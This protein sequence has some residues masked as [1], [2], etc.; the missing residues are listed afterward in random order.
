MLLLWGIDFEIALSHDLS[1]PQ[2]GGH[3]CSTEVSERIGREEGVVAQ[4]QILGKLSPQHNRDGC[5]QG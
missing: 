4:A 3:R 5:W 2:G 1:L